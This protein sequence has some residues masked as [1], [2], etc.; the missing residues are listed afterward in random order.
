MR[1][2]LGLTIIHRPC[3]VGNLIPSIV[4]VVT[5][6]ARSQH[7]PDLVSM[8]GLYVLHHGSVWKT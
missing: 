1:A 6:E 7:E 5:R 8:G 3:V 2:R 4:G